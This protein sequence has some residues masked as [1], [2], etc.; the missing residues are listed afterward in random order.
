ME[1]NTETYIEYLYLSEIEIDN[2]LMDCIDHIN[3]NISGIQKPHI[4][5]LYRGGIPLGI[6]LSHKIP[7]P[8]SIIDYQSYDDFTQNTNTE[9]KPIFIKNAGITANDLLVIV[10]DI[11]DTGNTLKL[12][13]EYVKKIYPYNKIIVY[14]IVG[15]KKHPYYYSIEHDD[16][17][18]IF[19]HEHI[20]DTR[21]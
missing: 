15:S 12:T 16:K 4:I 5:S 7:A 8:L 19:P 9:S 20:T 21:K 13:E 11:C 6:K 1:G 3:Q 10:D 18:I 17:W 2:G 14:T